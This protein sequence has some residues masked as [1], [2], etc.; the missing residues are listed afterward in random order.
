MPKWKYSINCNF[1]G[2]CA[3]KS[4]LRQPAVGWVKFGMPFIVIFQRWWWNIVASSPYQYL[5]LTM[6]LSSFGFVE[7]LESTIMS[8]IKPPVFVMLNPIQIKLIWNSI[9]SFDS[10]LQDWGVACV[11]EEA[12]LLKHLTGFN[13]F[14][15]TVLWERYVMPARKTIL[16]IPC[17]LTV[18]NEHD[19][20][21]FL[22]FIHFYIFIKS[23]KKSKWIFKCNCKP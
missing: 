6:L 8:L 21:N 11:E 1:E 20:M 4:I 14:L 9:P 15:F 16:H 10:S 23:L 19:L 18:S 2:L 17:R 12:S 7:S 3:W 13:C 22:Y 5:V